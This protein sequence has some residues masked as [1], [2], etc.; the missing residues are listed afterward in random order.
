MMYYFSEAQK[1]EPIVWGST[2]VMAVGTLVASGFALM[3]NAWACRTWLDVSGRCTFDMSAK[4]D[5][6]KVPTAITMV[7]PQGPKQLVPV[8]T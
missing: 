7:E 2:M 4:P 6:T 5:A 8:F 3:S 1:P